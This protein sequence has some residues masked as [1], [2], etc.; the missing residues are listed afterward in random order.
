[1]GMRSKMRV[2]AGRSTKFSPRPSRRGNRLRKPHNRSAKTNPLQRSRKPPTVSRRRDRED[3]LHR[4]LTREKRINFLLCALL[5][6]AV[7]LLHKADQFFG[8]AI[9][10][11][12]LVV[13]ELAPLRFHTALQLMPFALENLGIHSI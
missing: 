1:M 13:S 9:D 7:P 4:L 8:I 6:V 12:E 11:I 5:G 3:D 2:H 10:L